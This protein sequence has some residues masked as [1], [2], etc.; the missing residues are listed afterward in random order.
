MA[1]PCTRSGHSSGDTVVEGA[2][3]APA[4]LCPRPPAHHGDPAPLQGGTQAAAD[5]LEALLGCVGWEL[6]R[7]EKGF[8]HSSRARGATFQEDPVSPQL[9]CR[10]P[11]PPPSQSPPG[12]QRSPQH[13][14]FG[15]AEIWGCDIGGWL[16]CPLPQ[17]VLALTNPPWSMVEVCRHNPLTATCRGWAQASPGPTTSREWVQPS[18]KV[19]L[20]RMY[21][22]KERERLSPPSIPSQ[23]L[24]TCLHS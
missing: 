8:R 18:R 24:S 7:R 12:Q 2:L 20:P 13:R 19:T 5:A 10:A 14:R 4:L 21:T 23:H 6:W 15:G 9:P 1:L 17:P 16:L 22:R 11:W 3:P